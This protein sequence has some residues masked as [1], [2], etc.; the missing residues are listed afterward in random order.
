ML[1]HVMMTQTCLVLRQ[2]GCFMSDLYGQ[3]SH[4]AWDPA[5]PS[6]FFISRYCIATERLLHLQLIHATSLCYRTR[7]AVISSSSW[8]LL[9]P[10]LVLSTEEFLLAHMMLLLCCC[11]ENNW[12]P[13]AFLNPLKPT[14]TALLSWLYRSSLRQ[15]HSSL[16]TGREFIQK[17]LIQ[18]ETIWL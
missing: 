12:E 9:S 16:A 18:Q 8:G 3:Q 17:F 5:F 15:F 7:E 10:Y 4:A 6:L 11:Q 14:V 13:L 2:Q 1:Q